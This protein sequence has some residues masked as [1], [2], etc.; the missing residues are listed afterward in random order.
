MNSKLYKAK[1]EYTHVN[2]TSRIP[3]VTEEALINAVSTGVYLNISNFV[4]EAIKEKLE[5][6]G[7]LHSSMAKKGNNV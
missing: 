7:F 4:R 1:H 5:R 2:A 6:E 3:R